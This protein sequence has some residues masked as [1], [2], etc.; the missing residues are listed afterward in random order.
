MAAFNKFAFDLLF[1]HVVLLVVP[2]FFDGYFRILE[3][4]G[5]GWAV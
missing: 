4:G 3:G 5:E 1:N 2:L